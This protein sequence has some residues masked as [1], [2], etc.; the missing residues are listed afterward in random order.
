MVLISTIF[1]VNSSEE[2]VVVSPAEDLE[3]EGNNFISTLE[4]V[5]NRASSSSNRNNRKSNLFFS[6]TLTSGSLI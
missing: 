4:A 2:E 3:V 5:N 1:S 6:K